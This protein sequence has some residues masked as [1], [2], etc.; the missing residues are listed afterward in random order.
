MNMYVKKPIPVAATQWFTNGDHPEDNVA[1]IQKE[2]DSTFETEGEIV[3]Y[4]R[5]PDLDGQTLCKHCGDIMH[6]HGWIETLEGGHIVCPS[7]YIITGVA[8]EHYPCKADIFEATYEKAVEGGSAKPHRG[9]ISEWYPASCEDG[10]GYLIFG[11]S[12]DHPE[13]AGRDMHTSYIVKHDGNEIET[14]NSR[15]TLGDP[16]KIP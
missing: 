12:V 6:D 7:D 10:L 14:R 5:T 8:G 1:V 4:Y 16:V 3:R 13:F 2:D 9:T 11:V 15:Y